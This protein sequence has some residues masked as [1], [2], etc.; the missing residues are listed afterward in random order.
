VDGFIGN[1]ESLTN[2]KAQMRKLKIFEHISLDGVIQ[3]SADDEDFRYVDCA[4]TRVSVRESICIRCDFQ[5][6]QGR[7]VFETYIRRFT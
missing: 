4:L 6:L 2:R 7:R 3:N 1:A 5:L